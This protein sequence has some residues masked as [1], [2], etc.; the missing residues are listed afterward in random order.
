MLKHLPRPIKNSLKDLEPFANIRLVVADLD[1]T[2]LS[3][4][5]E[6][7]YLFSWDNIP[8]NDNVRLIEFLKQ[9]FNIDWIE[10]AK[11]EKFNDIR[12]ISVTTEK[13]SL[14]LIL[15]NEKT[16]ANLK[17]DDGR[18]DKFIAKME[19]GK[20]NIYGSVIWKTM[21][22][23]KRSTSN[24][25]DA[26]LTIATGRTLYGVKNL[27][28]FLMIQKD[29]PIVLYNGSLVLKSGNFQ[30]MVKKTIPLDILEQILKITKGK[31]VQI[32]A[33]F[34]EEDIYNK[35]NSSSMDFEYVLGW[36]EIER[37]EYEFNKMPVKWL[38]W[39]DPPIHP[40]SLLAWSDRE[41][42]SAYPSSLLAILIDIASNDADRNSIETLINKIP[43]ITATR[44]GSRF[45]EIRPEGSNKGQAIKESSS[46]LGYRRDE[47]LAIGDND[48]DA[49][50]L[51]WAGIGVA[52][53][54]SSK[55]ALES[56]DY[57]CDYDSTGGAIG[58]L[59][60][61]RDARRYYQKAK[62]IWKVV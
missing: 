29:L 19:N 18:T 21:Q 45:L 34:Y 61:V 20:L 59:R 8:G 39:G 16:I 33:Y 37:P 31:S 49:E 1:G 10:S 27:L 52:V 15:N 7:L 36:S 12:T 43:S 3:S 2:L 11:I 4:P 23:L 56:S 40:S 55:K 62:L 13:N 5:S 44:S 9:N 46:S 41:D 57:I 14:S 17:I 53:K 48:N 51:A 32:L 26:K 60:L 54:G 22:R 24:W 35:S 6:S 47:I 58:V 50:L 25:Y 30:D 28:K 38:N 42:A